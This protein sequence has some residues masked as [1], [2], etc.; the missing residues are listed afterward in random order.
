MCQVVGARLDLAVGGGA[1]IIGSGKN[2]VNREGRVKLGLSL[3]ISAY[4]R[5]QQRLVALS[6]HATK[7]VAISKMSNVKS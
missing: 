1:S 6:P 2:P 3:L 4:I 5:S 7:K